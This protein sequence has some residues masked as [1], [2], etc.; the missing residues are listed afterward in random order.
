VPDFNG[1]KGGETLAL[2]LDVHGQIG[3]QSV[4]R[5]ID[6]RVAIVSLGVENKLRAAV[7]AVRHLQLDELR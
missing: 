1:D 3:H 6:E 7:A 4:M 5:R 2:E